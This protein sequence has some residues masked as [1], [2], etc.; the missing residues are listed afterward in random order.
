MDR[1]VTAFNK[2]TFTTKL[3]VI[4]D[5]AFGFWKE[6]FCWIIDVIHAKLLLCFIIVST[7]PNMWL[8]KVSIKCWVVTF[9][10]DLWWRTFVTRVSENMLKMILCVPMLFDQQ[11]FR[12]VP[13]NPIES[14]PMHSWLHLSEDHL[15]QT[16]IW[17]LWSQLIIYNGPVSQMWAALFVD[18]YSNAWCCIAV[19]RKNK[20]ILN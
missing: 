4:I 19:V 17:M 1:T 12:E 6:N 16:R 14:W 5:S 9:W 13:I 20:L 8:L 10:W 11:L 7:S 3:A 15:G 2:T 18:E